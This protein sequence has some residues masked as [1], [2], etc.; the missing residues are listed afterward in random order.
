M[1]NIVKRNGA[2]RDIALA[3]RMEEGSPEE[4]ALELDCEKLQQ[5]KMETR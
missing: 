3:R 4:V 2:R 5:L 1:I